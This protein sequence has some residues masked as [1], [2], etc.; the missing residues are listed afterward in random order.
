[1]RA[2]GVKLRSLHRIGT[3]QSWP[4][5]PASAV[6][7][8]HAGNGRTANAMHPRALESDIGNDFL[9][10]SETHSRK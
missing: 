3:T 1:M 4:A 6:R 8:T 5:T 7:G 9:C 10:D 2:S